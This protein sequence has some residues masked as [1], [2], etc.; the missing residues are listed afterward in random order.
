MDRVY[1]Q[2]KGMEEEAKGTQPGTGCRLIGKSR[3]HIIML[4][5]GVEVI[6]SIDRDM[7]WSRVQVECKIKNSW[8]GPNKRETLI[9][10]NHNLNAIRGNASRRR[11]FRSL[12]VVGLSLGR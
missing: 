10:Y 3:Q 8:N 5:V 4:V 6:R 1:G 9:K 2:W 7:R 11:S 12:A